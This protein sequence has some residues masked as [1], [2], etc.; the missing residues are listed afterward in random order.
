MIAAL[1]IL[2]VAVAVWLAFEVWR[3]PL[4]C[5]R[6]EMP[7]EQCCCSRFQMDDVLARVQRKTGG[8]Q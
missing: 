5:N 1:I 4:C 7:L 8:E 2:G 6:C 3:A